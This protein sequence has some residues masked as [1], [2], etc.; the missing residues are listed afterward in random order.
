MNLLLK[1]PLTTFAAF[2]WAYF[3]LLFICWKFTD[4][5]AGAYHLVFVL[6]CMASIFLLFVIPCITLAL[7]V[8]EGK[9]CKPDTVI[10][11]CLS[12]SFWLLLFFGAM[13]S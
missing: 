2:P 1:Y 12:V 13:L 6:L 8:R 3:F 5:S 10:A 9:K 11:F 4:F 7:W